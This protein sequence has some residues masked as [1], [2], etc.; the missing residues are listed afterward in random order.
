MCF[1]PFQKKTAEKALKVPFSG[2]WDSLFSERWHKGGFIMNNTANSNITGAPQMPFQVFKLV[3]ETEQVQPQENSS[4]SKPDSKEEPK[5]EVIQQTEVLPAFSNTISDANYFE[6]K[7]SE[8]SI[9]IANNQMF[10]SGTTFKIPIMLLILLI[11]ILIGR[12]LISQP[13]KENIIVIEI[14]P[15]NPMS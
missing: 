5:V 10:L 3:P 13:L 4:T 14:P 2:G 9:I 15:R 11:Q 7:H 6:D 12:Y 1:P 8:H